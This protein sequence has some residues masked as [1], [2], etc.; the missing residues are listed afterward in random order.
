MGIFGIRNFVEVLSDLGEIDVALDC[1]MNPEFPSFA[2][3]ISKGATTLWEQWCGY[4]DMASH[5]HAMFAGSVSGFFTRLAGI[6]ST[7]TAFK[8]IQIKPVLSRH[9]NKLSTAIQT[10]NGEVKVEYKIV[11]NQF[12][13]KVVIPPNTVGEI[14]MPNGER[15]NV[16]NGTFKLVCTQGA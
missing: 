6:T 14:I 11:D 4:G 5:N 10:I 3:Q 9:I 13:L 7:D 15:H 1:F 12:E 8:K 2:H 16:G